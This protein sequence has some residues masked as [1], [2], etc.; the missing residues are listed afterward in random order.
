MVPI[1]P[2]REG[3]KGEAPPPRNDGYTFNFIHTRIVSRYD[4]PCQAKRLRFAQ[5]FVFFAKK[6]R[7]ITDG[8]RWAQV[9]PIFTDLF[10][11][12]RAFLCVF[13]ALWDAGQ[14]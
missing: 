7:L 2:L 3:G 6:L 10:V 14:D 8:R 13:M 5:F 4:L 12:I 9:E 1:T 11:G